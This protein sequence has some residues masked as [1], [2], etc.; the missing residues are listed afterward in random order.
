MLST[1]APAGKSVTT[2]ALFA[3]PIS[4]NEVVHRYG[5]V[6]LVHDLGREAEDGALAP[7][8]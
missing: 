8:A 2:D 6:T 7:A 3:C 5:V 1:V 4:A